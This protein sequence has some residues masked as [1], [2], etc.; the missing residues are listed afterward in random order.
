MAGVS[1]A[2]LVPAIALLIV[3]GLRDKVIFL[4]ARGEQYLPAMVFMAVL[5]PVDLI[6]ALKL[7]IVVVWIGAGVSKFGKHFV[8]VVPPMVSNAPFNPFRSLRRAHYRNFPDDLRPSHLAGFMA[9]AGGTAVEL[10][11]PLV[12]LFSPNPTV[13]LLAAIG[14]VVFHAFIFSTFPIAVPLE[15]NVLF[16]FGAVFL[17]VGHPVADGY[18]VL[19]FSQPWMLPVILGGLLFFPIL[20]NL[21]PDLVSFLPSMRQYAGNWA[22]ATWAFAPGCEARL[23]ELAKPAKNQVDQLVDLEYDPAVSEVLMQ[24]TMGWRTLHSQA[25]G[26]LSVL[27]HHLDDIDR[28]TIREAEFACNS[29]IGWNFGDGHLHDER[30]IAAIQRRLHFAPGEFVVAFVE[31]Q[32]IHKEHP[33]LPGHR[34]RP[35]R[36][37]TRHLEG[38]RRRRRAALAAQRADPADRRVDAARLHPGRACARARAGPGGMTTAVVVGSGPNGL[39]AAIRLAQEGLDV[40]VVERSDR[41]GGGTRTSELTLP[42]VLHDDCAAFHPTGV[43]SPFLRTLGLERFGLHLAVARGRP[44]PPAGRR[45][46]RGALA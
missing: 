28:Y 10:V 4:A 40:T 16:A 17:F 35:G 15:W 20:G 13:T 30:L 19:D 5:G 29:V 38:R 18:G 2:T 24:I 26:L 45:P 37:R 9:H 11:L 1:A 3:T 7:L 32:P 27:Q 36:G 41:P 22:T 14:M 46:R 21:R 12:L 39:A 42:G 31:S 33:G 23:N 8:N 44:R 6:I 34:R 25:R 43:A